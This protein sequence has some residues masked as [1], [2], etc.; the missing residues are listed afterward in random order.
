MYSFAFLLPLLLLLS[1]CGGFPLPPED[2]GEHYTIPVQAIALSDDDGAR[3]VPITA[4]EAGRW[5]AMANTSLA[6]SSAGFELAYDP[7]KDFEQKR[8]TTLNNLT[9]DG[10]GRSEGNAVAH[11]Y[12]G[13]IV[14]YF[15]HGP[16]DFFTGN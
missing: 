4:E 7:K 1:A 3:Q 13:K 16:D 2:S 5:I 9:S 11:Q 12:P 14:V 8:N 10:G 15:R 6:I